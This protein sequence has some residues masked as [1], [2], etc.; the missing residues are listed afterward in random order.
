MYSLICKNIYK[1]IFLTETKK[2]Y[3]TIIIL[4]YTNLI[5][6]GIK[7]DKKH[8]TSFVIG[9]LFFVFLLSFFSDKNPMYT[10][11]FFFTVYSFKELWHL[12]V[13]LVWN[14]C[15]FLTFAEK[16]TNT[17]WKVI[18]LHTLKNFTKILWCGSTVTIQIV[19]ILIRKVKHWWM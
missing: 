16:R 2:Y 6:Q 8:A 3:S 12:T 7:K 9:N 1:N 19:I 18:Y 10:F 15:R 11:K 13:L 17:T 14:V 4:W 5:D